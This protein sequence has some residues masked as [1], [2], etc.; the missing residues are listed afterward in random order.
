MKVFLDSNVLVAYLFVEEERFKTARDILAKHRKD[1]P[2]ASILTVHEAHYFAIKFGVEEKFLENVGKLKVALKI[3]PLNQETCFKAS[4]LRFKRS[5][6]E[7][8]ALILASAIVN[9]YDRFYTFDQDFK[10]LHR[11]SV[12]KTKVVW[13]GE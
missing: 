2:A 1:E 8:D 13:M 4:Y 7:V 11:K 9:D 10:N 5:L 3:E 6:P 12:E